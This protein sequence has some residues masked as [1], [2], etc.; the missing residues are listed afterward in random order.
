MVSLVIV[1]LALYA[2]YVP[3]SSDCSANELRINSNVC[4][5]CSKY[6]AGCTVSTSETS[7]SGC[8]PGMY[9][10]DGKCLECPPIPN[11]QLCTLGTNGLPKCTLC[12][13]GFSLVNGLCS[14]CAAVPNCQI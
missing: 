1:P 11:C 10:G 13:A 8:E 6:I 4:E 14:D 3:V 5:D 9:L 7:C 2:P 12:L